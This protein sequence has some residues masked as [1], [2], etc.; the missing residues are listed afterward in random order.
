[1]AMVLAE[2]FDAFLIDLD[3]VVYLGAKPLPHAAAALRKLRA[4][5]K[6]LRFLTNDPRPHRRQVT[7]RLI[8]CGIE[9]SIDEVITSG[10]AA[11][12]VANRRGH[13]SALVVGSDGLAE[14]VSDAGIRVVRDSGADVVIV[15][16]DERVCYPDLD[17]AVA[18]IMRG[19][20]FIATNR[21]ATYPLSPVSRALATGG[22]VAAIEAGS[23]RRP[24]TVGKPMPPMFKAALETLPPKTRVAVVGDGPRTD[25]EGARRTA[26][27]AI[28]VSDS[29]DTSNWPS[30]IT[31]NLVIRDLRDLFKQHPPPMSKPAVP[32]NW[33]FVVEAC[34]GAVVFDP[35]GHVLFERRHDSDV[36]ALPTGRIEPGES[37][38]EAIQR[39]VWEEIGVRLSVD[40]LC[41]V[42]SDPSRQ[43]FA[44]ESGW[45]MQAIMTVF[46]CRTTDTPRPDGV[47]VTEA[48]FFDVDE[49][50]SP[51]PFGD[52]EWVSD[53]IRAN[54][55]GEVALEY[56]RRDPLPNEDARVPLLPVEEAESAVKS[57]NRSSATRKSRR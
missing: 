55:T 4:G 44:Q 42:Y 21:D 25:I 28:L 49:L 56:S 36:W 15:G 3:G 20:E 23:G 22:I 30:V 47:E 27:F 9:A 13:R 16:C 35:A 19:A 11:A 26:L 7:S 18:T 43:V 45:V 34:V 41:G 14:E 50:P 6:Q 33:P 46:V 32:S 51:I 10:W 24:L 29:S 40:R 52:D 12:N 31:P 37:F 54:A 5:S 53:A 8:G 39:E 57:G 17:M 48:R 38:R 1:V 2:A